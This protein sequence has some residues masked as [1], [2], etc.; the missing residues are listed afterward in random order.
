ML[1]TQ[2][3]ILT[4][5]TLA[6]GLSTAYAEA[7]ACSG[8]DHTTGT[9]LGAIAGGIIGNQFGHGGGK[10]AATM[11]GVVLGGMAGNA[12][13]RDMDCHTGPMPS[14]AITTASTA[15][16]ANATNGVTAATTATSSRRANIGVVTGYAAIS[17]RSNSAVAANT[18]MTAPP[19]ATATD[20]GIFS[21]RFTTDV[22]RAPAR[23]EPGFA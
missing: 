9:V 5:A 7:D 15:T 20:S 21:K 13:S 14:A 18:T 10:V 3:R 2:G 12:I 1:K 4:I 16:S 23:Q 6:L 22:K 8:R 11:G 17:R 19:A